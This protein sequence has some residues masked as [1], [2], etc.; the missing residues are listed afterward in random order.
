MNKETLYKWIIGVLITVN[1]IQLVGFL[2]TPKPTHHPRKGHFR[3][4]AVEILNLN[5]IQ[6]EKFF[7]S[8]EKHRKTIDKLNNEQA[9]IILLQ[10][11]NPT[12]NNLNLIKEIEVEKIEATELN[13]KEIEE[14]LNPEQKSNFIKFKKQA[15]KIILR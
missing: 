6:R 15:L 14:M 13:F 1:C 2:F 10:F 8:A 3:E 5:E 9:E 12:K 4:R 11:D 7:K